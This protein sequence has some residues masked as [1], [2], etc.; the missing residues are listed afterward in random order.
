MGARQLERRMPRCLL[1]AVFLAASVSIPAVAQHKHGGDRGPGHGGAHHQ[2]FDDPE[3][4]SKAFDDPK[5]AEWQKPDEVVKALG[6]KPDMKVVDLGAGTGYFAVRLARAVP[7]GK[8]YA[9]DLGPKTVAYLAQRATKEGL[10]NL[11]AV[12]GSV[13]SANLP[14]AVDLVLLVNVFHHIDNRIGYM[15]TLAKSLRPGGRIAIIETTL[16]APE[17]PPR[18]IRM[19]AGSV[20]K[21]MASAGFARAERLTFLPQ[22]SFQIFQVKR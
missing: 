14:E 2:S 4:W 18:S 8:V 1:I 7:A 11:E 5:R 9:V 17:G 20:E 22:Q 15:R 16:E 12:Q 10:S 6:L 13:T 19:S 21:D 3:R